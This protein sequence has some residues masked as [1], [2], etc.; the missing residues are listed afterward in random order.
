MFR[1]TLFVVMALTALSGVVV[2]CSGPL[3]KAEG[4]SCDSNDS[5]EDGLVCQPIGDGGEYCCPTPA[6]VSTKSSCKSGNEG[7]GS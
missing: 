2:A 4:D 7:N 6:S 3:G 5:C 1:K